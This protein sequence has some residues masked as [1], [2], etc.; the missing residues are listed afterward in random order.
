[1]MTTR[2]MIKIMEAFERGE[3]IQYA[4]KGSEDWFVLH[5]GMWRWDDYDYRITPKY[6]KRHPEGIKFVY[7]CEA[8]IPNPKILVITSV[9]TPVIK[10]NKKPYEQDRA[11]YILTGIKTTDKNAVVIMDEDNLEKELIRVDDCLWY[12]DVLGSEGEWFHTNDRFDKQK[13]LECYSGYTELIPLYTL[14]FRLP[15]ENK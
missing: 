11:I 10:G 3:V 1:M 2:E 13:A 9:E 4:R 5:I 7:R 15:K 14:G 8:G 12:W 6:K